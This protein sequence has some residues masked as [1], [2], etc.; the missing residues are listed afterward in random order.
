MSDENDHVETR[1]G[2]LMVNVEMHTD[3]METGEFLQR[4]RLTIVTGIDMWRLAAMQ[5]GMFM[6]LGYSRGIMVTKSVVD[7]SLGFLGEV[8][9]IP[10]TIHLH[11]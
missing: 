6:A 11:F 8:G 4:R 1:D 10:S 5:S 2:S 3:L 9:K 7:A